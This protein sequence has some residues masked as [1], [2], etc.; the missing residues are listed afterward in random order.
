MAEPIAVELA[1]K[2]KKPVKVVYERLE[3]FIAS[4]T[5]HAGIVKVKLGVK[6]DGTF[7]AL[8]MEGILN[9]GAYCS[10]GTETIGVLGAMG[11]SVYYTPNMLYQGN[12]VYTNTTPAGAFRGF[13]NPQAMFALES[14]VDMVAEKLGM[15]PMDLRK[16]NI[17][18]P[19]DPWILPYKCLS[20]GLAECMEKGAAEIGWN[21]RNEQGEKNGRIRKG[22]GMAVGT[23]VS[24]AW[25]FCG[26][27]SSVYIQMLNDGSVHL[28]SAVPDMGQGSKT[29]L[30]QFAAE[31]L[32]V[33]F[34]SV[35]V[36]I[37]DTQSAPFDIGSHASRT[38][39][40]A[41]QAVIQAAKEVRRQI[42]E[43]ASEYLK[44]QG[45]EID[46]VNGNIYCSGVRKMP[47]AELIKH[48]HL[49]NRQFVST[50]KVVPSNA[51]PWLAHFAEVEVDIETGQVKVVKLVAAH[52]VGK[53][54]NPIIVEGQLEGG[55][56]QGMGYALTEE[57][58][59]DSNGKQLHDLYHKY[60]IPTAEDTPEIKAIIVETNDPTGPFGAKGVG[61][62]GLVATAPAIANAVYNA[63]GIRFNRIPLTEERV[64][65]AI[66]DTQKT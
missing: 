47:I 44:E 45:E 35:S 56:V 3:D 7:H 1:M 52:D 6:K 10:F 54:I 48:A 57:I 53:A 38:C 60:M 46:I 59:Y 34:S 9:T 39:Y 49:N 42:I 31:I 37:A 50:G 27:F 51:P 18:K 65:K 28:A 16:K 8:H 63:I 22:I 25:P 33:D 5:R 41:G 20:S 29:T 4:D 64:F 23:H 61:E 62:T 58:L 40:V 11:L 24:N 55:L 12:S 14:V 13:G 30:G 32:G 21:K 19:G 26:D 43:Y 36:T 2:S 15:D 17:I 66:K